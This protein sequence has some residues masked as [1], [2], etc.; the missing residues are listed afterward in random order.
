MKKI[1]KYL[2]RV[3]LVF[4]FGLVLIS[5]TFDEQIDSNGPSLE[6]FISNASINQLNNL[7]VG[8]ESTMRNGLGVSTVTS[9]TMGRELYIF[10]ADPRNT[11]ILLGKNGSKL[12][13]GDF[14]ATSPW[15]GSY[16]AIK[17]ANVLIKSAENSQ[18]VTSQ[19]KNGYLGFAKT[20]IAYEL[21]EVLKMYNKARVDVADEKNLGGILEFDKAIS[22]V[23]EIL[24]EASNNLDSAG[25]TFEF[26]LAGFDDF[27]TPFT[28]KKFNR[29]VY[30]LASI[31]SGDKAGAKTALAQSYLNLNGNLMTG[32]KHV[33]SLASGDTSNPIYKGPSTATKP[34]NGDQLVVHNSWISDAEPSD[35]RVTSKTALRP[36]PTAQ[37][38]LNGTHETRLYATNVSPIYILRNEELI[39]LYAE[40]NIGSD[41]P[42]A[43]SA[44]N[45]VRNGAGLL[46][47]SGASDDASVL[48]E[49][50]KQRRYSLWGENH[51]MFD[52]RRYN[53]SST[54]P[55]DRAGDVVYNVMPIPFTETQ[56]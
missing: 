4:G 17:N 51:R 49:L 32:P 8:V 33:F 24:N 3:L 45:K 43:I 14:Y 20:V 30:A 7:V 16:R 22:K 36:D 31:Y 48:A 27:N 23:R 1:N 5:C 40:A 46:N 44:I 11:E 28:F 34:N 52:L 53:L 18:S 9:G 47:Y 2:K 55:I 12:G 6:G 21:I 19:Q 56:N 41:N 50:L 38:G 39:L 10:D 25:S 35:A 26:S 13:N 37:D 29:A 42:E 54:L 15:A